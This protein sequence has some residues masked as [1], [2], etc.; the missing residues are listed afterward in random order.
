MVETQ[1]DVGLGR[2]ALIWGC[3]RLGSQ[4]ALNLQKKGYLRVYGTTRSQTKGRRLVDLGVEPIFCDVNEGLTLHAIGKLPR[5]MVLDIFYCVAPGGDA[6][7]GVKTLTRGLSGAVGAMSGLRIGR[8]VYVSSTRVYGDRGGGLVD[9]DTPV[10][11]VNGGEKFLLSAEQFWLREMKRLGGRGHVVRLAGLYDEGRVV[12]K[13]GLLEGKPIVGDADGAIN[14]IHTSDAAWLLVDVAGSDDAGEI[15]LGCDEGGV[16]R[17]D[18]YDDLA[19]AYGLG[20]PTYL[21]DA[22]A[23]LLGID[24]TGRGGKFKRCSNG[25]TKHRCGWAPKFASYREGL[26]GLFL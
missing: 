25:V 11:E 17:R 1:K 19:G 9:A 18:Y 20:R 10:G 2:G 12:G 7:I 24:M 3:G 21:S 26:A 23:G 6:E 22:D 8:G 5:D 14:L 4:L 16:S 13:R 15:E